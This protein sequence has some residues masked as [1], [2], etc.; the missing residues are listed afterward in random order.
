MKEIREVCILQMIELDIMTYI[1]K[2]CRE[3]NLKYFLAYGTLIGAVRHRGFIP[4]DDDIDILMP[5]DDYEKF[6][7]IIDHSGGRY[8]ICHWKKD[9]N[10]QFGFAKVYDSS[11]KL[12]EKNLTG[13]TGFG[14]YVDVFPYDGYPG[15]RRLRLL[16]I[17]GKCR[18]WQLRGFNSMKTEAGRWKNVPRFVLYLV[19]CAVGKRNLLALSQKLA[20]GTKIDESELAGCFSSF[21]NNEKELFHKTAVDS[22]D[23]VEFEGRKFLIP[24]GYDELL[25]NMYGD[26]M[27]LPPAEQRVSNHDFVAWID[28]K[29]FSRLNER[30]N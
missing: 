16:D 30:L 11:T 25:T 22:V 14:V 4:W 21:A 28:E 12:K 29:E 2:V 17:L 9:K 10:Y 23:E 15:A 27:K 1:D 20:T 8:K 6:C 13:G 5:R 24:S 26:Y 7:G 19:L 3:N 18:H